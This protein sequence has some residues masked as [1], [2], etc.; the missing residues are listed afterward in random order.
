MRTRFITRLAVLLIGLSVT[1]CL[2]EDSRTGTLVI[3]VETRASDGAIYHMAGTFSIIDYNGSPSV[4][5]DS[6]AAGKLVEVDVPEGGWLASFSGEVASSTDETATWHV[7]DAAPPPRGNEI[8]SGRFAVVEAGHSY[9]IRFTY[10]VQTA[11]GEL[12][13]TFDRM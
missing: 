8:P 12:T 9:T 1:G 6:T 5:V 2:S 4:S 13:V 7:V 3:P 11:I 10:V